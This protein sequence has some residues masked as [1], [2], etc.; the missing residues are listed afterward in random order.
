MGN[1]AQSCVNGKNQD[2]R[3][4]FSGGWFKNNVR[5]WVSKWQ[6]MTCASIFLQSR[7]CGER[8]ARCLF[9]FRAK[10]IGIN[11]LRKEGHKPK[12]A[13]IHSSM[14]AQEKNKFQTCSKVC[15]F[16]LTE[17][18]VP[19]AYPAPQVRPPSVISGADP[20]CKGLACF[21]KTQNERKVPANFTVHDDRPPSLKQ[22]Q[23]R[24]TA[25]C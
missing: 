5:V 20:K 16:F 17:I 25:K 24:C 14:S 4:Q 8:L 22:K 15:I 18:Q 9:L 10:N 23:Q 1:L 13:K 3:S 12:I 2:N 7:K 6:L 21:S 11:M 19:Q